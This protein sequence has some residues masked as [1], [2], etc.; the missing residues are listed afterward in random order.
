MWE[1]ESKCGRNSVSFPRILGPDAGPYFLNT[2]PAFHEREPQSQ[3]FT[4]QPYH[5]LLCPGVL[6][7]PGSQATGLNVAY[8]AMYR[9]LIPIAV[10]GSLACACLALY[11]RS[12]TLPQNQ[13][14]PANTLIKAP[15]SAKVEVSNKI[16]EYTLP[17]D[18]YRKA[19]NRGRIRF[20][21]QLFGLFYGVFVL[22]VIL[23]SRLA[24]LFR[25]W[26]ESR[27]QY[28]VVQALI[29]VPLL[30]VTIGVFRLPLDTFDE[31]VLK[32][33]RISVQSW[34]SWLADWAQAQGILIAAGTLLTYIL[35]HTIRKSPRR[36]WFYSWVIALPFV[37]FFVFV[38]PYVIDPLFNH[39]EPLAAKA[40]QLIEGL[41]RVS[42]R[43]GQ[44]IPPER[45]FWMLASDKTIATNAS[46]DGI[47]ASKRI[48]IWDT[49]L[50][51]ESSDEI[52]ADFG[53]E[54][55]HYVLQHIWKGLFFDCGLALVLL[56]LGYLSIGSLLSRY[57]S[58]WGIRGLEDWASL[59]ALLLLI[60]LFGFAATAISNTFTRYQENHADIYS[61]EVIHGIV[62]DGGHVS[63]RQFQKFGE[64]VL[65]DPAPNPV[66]VFL[67]YQH[68]PVPD[69]IRLF[70]TYDPWSSGSHP[71][72]VD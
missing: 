7:C 48:V 62:P 22:W 4:S 16:T 32:L 56:F 12:S 64:T 65:M 39:Y 8:S 34:P 24:V 29:F 25:N 20:A 37:V 40:P 71:Q 50:A 54:L 13:E 58:D 55:G 43:V 2:G 57:G 31:W 3:P 70:A 47:G 21:S 30:G 33:Y 19:R 6:L 27:S 36:W 66:Q 17:P 11:A 69:R 51:Q 63:A 10:L 1:C 42:R 14:L 26:A 41:Q 28:R 9:R 5:H 59:P 60:S 72:F 23:K 68:P 35:Y 53:H 44:G 18:L 45:M 46:V 67:F 52:L 15:A 49:S 38:S 61:L